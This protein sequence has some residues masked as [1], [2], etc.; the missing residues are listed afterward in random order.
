MDAIRVAIG[1]RGG[2]DLALMPEPEV[3]P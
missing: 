3:T 2:D 1:G